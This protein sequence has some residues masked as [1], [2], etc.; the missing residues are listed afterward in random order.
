MA[1][2]V[3][4][5]LCLYPLSPAAMFNPAGLAYLSLQYQASLLSMHLLQSTCGTISLGLNKSDQIHLGRD[6]F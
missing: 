3:P 1:V 2:T 4:H 6:G 5:V